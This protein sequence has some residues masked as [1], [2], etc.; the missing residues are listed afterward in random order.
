MSLITRLL[1]G[2]KRRIT[3]VVVLNYNKY[4]S[5]CETATMKKKLLK[6]AVIATFITVM[7]KQ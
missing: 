7:C 4:L 3:G 5:Q 2:G 1:E 6:V